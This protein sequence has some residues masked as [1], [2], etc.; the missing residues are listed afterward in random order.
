MPYASLISSSPLVATAASTPTAPVSAMIGDSPAALARAEA[1]VASHPQGSQAEDVF[2]RMTAGP[3]LSQMTAAD[4]MALMHRVHTTPEY[5]QATERLAAAHEKLDSANAQEVNIAKYLPGR[6]VGFLLTMSG[7]LAG[8]FGVSMLGLSGTM[9][10]VALSAGLFGGP[11]LTA[12]V[13]YQVAT[14]RAKPERAALEQT[15][16]ACRAQVQQCE[17]RVAAA[18]QQRLARLV[19]DFRQR[20]AEAS[21]PSAP[22]VVDEPTSVRIG[23]LVVPKRTNG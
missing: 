20:A 4:A 19:A 9:A 17:N 16:E 21:K 23:G 2:A 12:L 8:I 10:N 13:C 1:R 6:D 15:R 3:D 14:A 7:P 11:L 18:E 5:I 22:T